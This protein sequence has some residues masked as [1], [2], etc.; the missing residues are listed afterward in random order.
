MWRFLKYESKIQVQILITL[1]NNYLF[2]ISCYFSRLL[3]ERMLCR[4]KILLTF[5]HFWWYIMPFFCAS[6]SSWIFQPCLELSS[7]ETL[8]NLQISK[9]NFIVSNQKE[10]ALEVGKRSV[11]WYLSCNI[12]LTSIDFVFLQEP[13]GGLMG[14]KV[15]VCFVVYKKLSCFIWGG[16]RVSSRLG[17]MFM[18]S[19][20]WPYSFIFNSLIRAWNVI[21]APLCQILF[22]PFFCALLALLNLTYFPKYL[23]IV[24]GGEGETLNLDETYLVDKCISEKLSSEAERLYEY[25]HFSYG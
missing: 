20:G 5:L 4:G 24:E 17:Q 21:F 14:E 25:K 10:D 9:G 3:R 2:I 15:L 22:L 8:W 23:N 19:L 12:M 18:I 16:G 7:C 11:H 6:F 13:T 1:I